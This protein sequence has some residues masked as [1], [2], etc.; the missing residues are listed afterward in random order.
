MFDFLLKT[1]LSHLRFF[2]DSALICC[3]A[4]TK[5]PK[6]GIVYGPCPKRRQEKALKRKNKN[7][8]AEII[9]TKVQKLQK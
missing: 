3:L 2:V 6:N 9:K 8:S 1:A 7:K 5:K 4:S